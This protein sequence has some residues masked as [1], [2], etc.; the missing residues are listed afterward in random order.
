MALFYAELVKSLV[1]LVSIVFLSG[2]IWVM[3][4]ETDLGLQFVLV[5]SGGHK[6]RS[7]E[8]LDYLPA[9][10]SMAFISIF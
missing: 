4:E 5:N 1:V 3:P 7:N 10:I 2:K 8:E 9:E 6:I